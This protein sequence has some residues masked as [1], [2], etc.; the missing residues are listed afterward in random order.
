[1]DTCEFSREDDN[2]IEDIYIY[3]SS[4]DDT[5]HYIASSLTNMFACCVE[6]SVA[7]GLQKKWIVRFMKKWQWSYQNSNTKGAFLAT[8]SIEMEEM[9]KAHRMQRAMLGVD[10]RLVL[11]FDQLWKGSYDPAKRVLH[12]LKHRNAVKDNLRP[13]DA[14]KL[15]AIKEMVTAEALQNMSYP[16]G[17]RA[18]KLRKGVP[19]TV[20]LTMLLSNIFGEN[21]LF[22]RFVLFLYCRQTKYIVPA[23]C[24][25][26]LG[27]RTSWSGVGRA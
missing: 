14:G 12:K 11:N 22:G 15:K 23:S 16:S 7:Q 2:W 6:S 4:Y 20:C 18:S 27:G 8:T 17:S 3:N 25:P 1:M 26:L 21:L 10:W 5:A 9:R 24:V 13:D 19:R